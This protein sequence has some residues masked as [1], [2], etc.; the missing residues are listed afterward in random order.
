M[1]HIEAEIVPLLPLIFDYE[2]HSC[3]PGHKQFECGDGEC[4]ADFDTCLNKRHLLI[5]ASIS[6]Q[7]HLSY[8]CWMAI[9]CLTKIRDRINGTSCDQFLRSSNISTYL[10]TCEDL[11]QFPTVSVLF[12]HVRFLYRL[13]NI[14]DLN[15]D[16]SLTPDYVC[17]DQQL[18]DFLIPT[19]FHGNYS[20]RYSHEFGFDWNMK[21]K[22]WASLIR[23]VEPYFRKC[24]T[25]YKDNNKNNSHHPSLYCCKN[26]SKCISK[27]RILDTIS[28]CHLNDDEEQFELSCLGPDVLRFKCVNEIRCYSALFPKETCPSWRFRNF[29]EIPFQQICDR[30]VHTLPVTI[31]EKTYTD[32][33]ECEYWPCSNIYTRCD[34]FW[35]C[36]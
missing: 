34:S 31:N 10:E 29:N 12:G 4:V 17:Y 21:P 32:E 19:Y 1:L 15:M 33:T 22:N 2:E 14:H 25:R 7:G 5:T 11:I 18:C 6:V 36:P 28:D 20:C 9:V 35:N 26:S 27:H 16:L 23:L 24:L 13:K 8:T 3:Q 30:H